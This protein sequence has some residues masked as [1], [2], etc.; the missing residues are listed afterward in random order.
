MKRYSNIFVWCNLDSVKY[1]SPKKK[2]RIHKSFPKVSVSYKSRLVYFHFLLWNKEIIFVRILLPVYFFW[3][4]YLFFSYASLLQETGSILIE[5]LHYL[6]MWK[7]VMNHHT[8]CAYFPFLL[9]TQFSKRITYVFEKLIC[10]IVWEMRTI[11][12]NFF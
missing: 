3:R 8:K 1:L 9:F 2:S 10:I 6:C 5:Y 12:N 4:Y 11:I 7:I